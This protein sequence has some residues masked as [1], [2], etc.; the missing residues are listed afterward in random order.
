M[1]TSLFAPAFSYMNEDLEVK[2]RGFN[3]L[4]RKAVQAFGG[5]IS[6]LFTQVR[7]PIAALVMTVGDPVKTCRS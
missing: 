3:C 4:I 1:L 2:V 5:I 6:H 7:D